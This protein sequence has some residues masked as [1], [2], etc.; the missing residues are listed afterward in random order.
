MNRAQI[1]LVREQLLEISNEQVSP[2]RLRTALLTLCEALLGP[3]GDGPCE[4]TLVLH[5][6]ST[7]AKQPKRSF[8][9]GPNVVCSSPPRT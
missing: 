6:D 4:A 2:L 9:M 8:F 7:S 5:K 1:R 3:S